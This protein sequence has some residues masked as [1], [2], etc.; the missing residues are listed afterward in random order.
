MISLANAGFEG[1]S[2]RH[3]GFD[4]TGPY[5]NAVGGAAGGIA[6]TLITARTTVCQLGKAPTA[7]AGG[8]RS[9]AAWAQRQTA[10]AA[11]DAD[12]HWRW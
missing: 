9:A 8:A 6:L 4:L 5:R 10:T 12:G 11:D 7:R 2:T 1:A 3:L